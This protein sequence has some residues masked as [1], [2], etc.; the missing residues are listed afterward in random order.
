LLPLGP[1]KR[2]APSARLQYRAPL[3]FASVDELLGPSAKIFCVFFRANLRAYVNVRLRLALACFSRFYS[4]KWRFFR[5][6]KCDEKWR[7][8]ERP[9]L[10]LTD[11]AFFRENF[12]KFGGE[13][14]TAAGVFEPADIHYHVRIGS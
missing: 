12:A 7:L 10:S 6:A 11:L 13:K 5:G 4:R 1:A 14:E 3:P 8:F 2:N 9:A